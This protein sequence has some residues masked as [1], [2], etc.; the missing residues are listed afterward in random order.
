MTYPL[1]TTNETRSV[2]CTCKTGGLGTNALQSGYSGLDSFSTMCA[3]VYTLECVVSY[4]R[5]RIMNANVL[6]GR[7]L[8]WD[9]DVATRAFSQ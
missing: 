9:T 3:P 4:S 7:R 2:D 1:R 6:D 8:I 5:F